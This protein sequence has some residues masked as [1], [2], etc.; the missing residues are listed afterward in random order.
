MTH[1]RSP[2]VL[3]ADDDFATCDLYTSYLSSVGYR[4]ETAKDG[5]QA[6]LKARLMRPAVIIMDLAM[7]RVDGWRAIKELR[8]DPNTAKIPIVV[9]TG[10]DLRDFLKPAAVAVG[11]TTYLKKPCSPDRLAIEI[12]ERLR[13]SWTGPLRARWM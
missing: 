10:H 13:A 5:Y 7:P 9:L 4:V 2:L 11:A 6:V 8:D 12:G 3:I 1:S